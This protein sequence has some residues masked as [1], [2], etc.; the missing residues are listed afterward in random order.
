MTRSFTEEKRD[1]FRINFETPV[2][3]NECAGS[4]VRVLPTKARAQN[5]SQSGIMFQTDE[6]PPQLSSV[7]WMNLDIRTLRICQEIE[8]R[9]LIF[10]NG[11]LGRVVRVEENPADEV[12]DVGVCFLTRDQKETPEVKQILAELSKQSA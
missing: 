6:N 3:F 12:Y 1:F 7:L 5:I 4:A 10:N 11:L 9:A 8:K 2:E